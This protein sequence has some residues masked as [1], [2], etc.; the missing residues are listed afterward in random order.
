MDFNSA[1]DCLF[2]RW[3][4]EN[5]MREAHFDVH[6]KIIRTGAAYDNRF[7]SVI[8]IEDRKIVQWRDYMDS[9]TA[10]TAIGKTQ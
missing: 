7:I 5:G 6:G 4:G 2:D 9:L 3:V 8:T 10:M 1:R